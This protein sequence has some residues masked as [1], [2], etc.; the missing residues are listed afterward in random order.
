MTATTYAKKIN[1]KECL[2]FDS[3]STLMYSIFPPYKL[4]VL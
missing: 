3:F 1:P 2:V 4:I